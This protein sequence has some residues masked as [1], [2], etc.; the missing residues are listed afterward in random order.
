MIFYCSEFRE[1]AEAGQVICQNHK[2]HGGL[3]IQSLIL[4]AVQPVSPYLFPLFGKPA[5]F[6]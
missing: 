3:I 6:P 5:V 1:K 4:P 2:I